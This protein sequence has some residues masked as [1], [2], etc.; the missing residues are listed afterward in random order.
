M[1]TTALI[2]E[3]LRYQEPQTIQKAFDMKFP[4]ALYTPTCTWH[5]GTKYK[6]SINHE[7]APESIEHIKRMV[8]F[9]VDGKKMSVALMGGVGNGKTTLAMSTLK[10]L[11]MAYRNYC[12]THYGGSRETFGL[13]A[14][15]PE[16]AMRSMNSLTM[17]TKCKDA[18]LLVIDDLG[19]EAKEVSCYGNIITP[20]ADILSSRY[21]DGKPTIITT[22]LDAQGIREKYGDRIADRMREQFE[23]IPFINP[24]FR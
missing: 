15:A 14:D 5:I 12:I 8:S 3:A 18:H 22:N 11:N 9:L 1:V 2:G 4:F 7:I 17:L 20:V 10:T 21:R 16:I 13:W 24:S 19:E 6:E 23:I